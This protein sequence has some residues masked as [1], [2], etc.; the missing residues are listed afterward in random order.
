MPNIPWKFFAPS[1][2][3]PMAQVTV[4][5]LGGTTATS[6]QSKYEFQRT[7]TTFGSLEYTS[8]ARQ[9]N[10]IKWVGYLCTKTIH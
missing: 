10:N 9:Q 1:S 7:Q 2:N 3:N 6:K 5:K 8:A 4:K